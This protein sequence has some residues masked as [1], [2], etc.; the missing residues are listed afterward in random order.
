M[1]FFGFF[2]PI[3]GRKPNFIINYH[4]YLASFIPSVSPFLNYSYRLL[5]LSYDS[6]IN[7]ILLRLGINLCVYLCRQ[8]FFYIHNFKNIGA[9]PISIYSISLCFSKWRALLYTFKGLNFNISMP[10]LERKDVICPL[11]ILQYW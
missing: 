1:T 11:A 8:F 6:V 4:P 5:G 10:L 3:L 7:V 9:Y 2:P